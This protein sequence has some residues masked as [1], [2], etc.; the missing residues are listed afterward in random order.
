MLDLGK[1]VFFAVNKIL[2]PQGRGYFFC[3]S[4]CAKVAHSCFCVTNCSG[5]GRGG[6]PS[7]TENGQEVELG[8]RRRRSEIPVV[9]VYAVLSRFVKTARPH[10]TQYTEIF[11][12]SSWLLLEKET[13]LI[14]AYQTRRL[15]LSDFRKK[16]QTREDGIWL[17]TCTGYMKI[18]AH[19][20]TRW[21]QFQRCS[22]FRRQNIR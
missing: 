15:F 13:G 1:D 14:A 11:R 20:A 8:Y 17:R 10:C 9:A 19:E 22:V 18:T 16:K 7:T 3:C 12:R 6:R 5:Y 21:L 2:N 4:G